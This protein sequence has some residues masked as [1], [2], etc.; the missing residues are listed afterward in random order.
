MSQHDY[1]IANQAGAGFRADLNS[2][3]AAVVSNNS[4]ASSP[5]TTFSYE[6]WADTTLGLLKIRNAANT[7]W[8]TIGALATANLGLAVI[9]NRNAWTKAQDVAQ[10]TLTDAAN[11]ATD[12]SLSNVFLVTL[13]GNRTLDNPTNLVAGQTVIW[14]LRQDATGGRTLAYGNLFKF[15]VGAPT[16]LSTGIAAKDVLT[17]AY[18]GAALLCALQKGFA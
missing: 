18:D 2:A 7:G 1:D 16:T 3:L 13:A 6:M 14:N 11:I 4:G 15:P 5:A 8:V 9:D 10:V 17:C 12:A